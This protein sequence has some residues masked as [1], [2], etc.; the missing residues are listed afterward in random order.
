MDAV[1][2]VA[3]GRDHI[4]ATARSLGLVD[5][6]ENQDQAMEAL[7]A[8]V[9]QSLPD[10]AA[11]PDKKETEMSLKTSVGAVVG[12]VVSAVTG[13]TAEPVVIAPAATAAVEPVV[14]EPAPAPASPPVAQEPAAPAAASP[15]DV[16]AI[17]AERLKQFT[18][19]FGPA[20]A[21]Y[22]AEG[23]TFTEAARAHAAALTAELEIAKAENVKLKARVE[24]DRGS[25]TPASFSPDAAG[26]AEAQAD[27]AGKIG[28]N[29]A[30]FA[31]GIVFAKDK[32]TD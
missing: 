25:P 19:A 14:T 17:V 12:A 18:D 29:L 8:V 27:L 26:R 9:R 1:R 30:R 16:S 5:G 11:C 2:Q 3:D 21:K 23:K 24:R 7:R 6:V 31:A 22:L 10:A 20:G 28:P 15:P 4:A 13:K 32:K